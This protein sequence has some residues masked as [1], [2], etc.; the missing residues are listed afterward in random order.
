MDGGAENVAR[1][2]VLSNCGSSSRARERGWKE[3]ACISLVSLRYRQF[4]FMYAVFKPFEDNT[5]REQ[6]PALT[7]Q[8]AYS[9]NLALPSLETAVGLLLY[10]SPVNF[11]PCLQGLEDIHIEN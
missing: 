6:Q 4:L 5:A 3:H 9:R 11:S 7:G 10:L 8:T 2:W 1:N